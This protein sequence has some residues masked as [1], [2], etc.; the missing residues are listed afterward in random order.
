MQQTL[1]EFQQN[2]LKAVSTQLNKSNKYHAVLLFEHENI[3]GISNKNDYYLYGTLYFTD[4]MMA[5]DAYANIKCP[6]SQLISEN[7]IEEL[8]NSINKMIDNFHN[9]IWLE[10]N[11]YPYL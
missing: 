1:Q 3:L 11:L 6:A 5:L 9:Q 7:S 8:Y 2:F 4:A 10:Q